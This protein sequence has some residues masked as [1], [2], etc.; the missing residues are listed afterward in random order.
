MRRATGLGVVLPLLLWAQVARAESR[1]LELSTPTWVRRAPA[2]APGRRA[3]P[4]RGRLS[5]VSTADTLGKG[6]WSFTSRGMVTAEFALGVTDWLEVGFKNM[7]AL[8]VVPEGAQNT[9]WLGS[10][11]LR[12]LRTRSW[13]LTAEVEGLSLLGWAGLRAGLQSRLGGDRFAFHAHASGIRM[14]QAMDESWVSQKEDACNG[15]TCEEQT[16]TLSSL[17]AG[18]G[19]D[20]RLGRKVK[21]MLDASY[22]REDGP[23]L[24]VV[25]PAVRLHG[26]HFAI[27]LGVLALHRFDRQE[28]Y[29]IPLVN[30]S[31]T[32]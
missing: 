13:T 8:L 23:G 16:P 2:A 6:E 25:A 9:L 15:G 27:D 26:R 32:Y 21:L 24:L 3:D 7:P 19:L 18:A 11:R 5:V 1:D 17:M 22:L 4:A 29:L 14:W 28:G 30:L 10:L 20:V 31:V 12:L